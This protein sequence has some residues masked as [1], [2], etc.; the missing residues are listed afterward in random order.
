[1]FGV[2]MWET[3]KTSCQINV[4]N[5]KQKRYLQFVDTVH[6]QS[7]YSNFFFISRLYFIPPRSH[8]AAG[9]HSLTFFFRLIR[10]VLLFWTNLIIGSTVFDDACQSV[11]VCVGFN[12]D[13]FYETIFPALIFS[14]ILCVW[15]SVV[16]YCIVFSGSHVESIFTLC[17]FNV[18][19]ATM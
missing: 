3:N 9:T 2:L 16:S 17:D 6:N 10:F 13:S 4:N 12:S 11:C 15:A 7:K 5:G 8:F 1:M 19:S 14:D 18:I